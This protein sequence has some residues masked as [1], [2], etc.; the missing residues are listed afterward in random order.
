[1]TAPH[2]DAIRRADR[3]AIIWA[4]FANFV[5]APGDDE[6]RAAIRDR[7]AHHGISLSD[8]PAIAHAARVIG[9]ETLAKLRRME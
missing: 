1:M 7:A 6:T 5:A 4:W 8:M 3:N 2:L 9:D